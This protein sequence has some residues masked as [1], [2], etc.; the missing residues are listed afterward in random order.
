MFIIEK[1]RKFKKRQNLRKL[2]KKIEIGNSILLDGFELIGSC[3][4]KKRIRIGNDSM[5][6]CKIVFESDNGEVIIGD[7]VFLGDCTI[8]CR[9][10]IIFENDIFVA[11]GTYFYDHDS[12][13]SNFKLRQ[14][15]MKQQLNDFRR[16]H[17]FIKNKNWSVVKSG[18]IKV[19]SNSWIGMNCIILKR[20]TIGEG[21][22]IGAGSV[23]TKDILP[24]TVAAG[25][26]AKIVKNLKEKEV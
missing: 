15:D 3:N 4:N 19:S 11:W 24:W 2:R 22:I 16:G 13:S 6:A 21:A 1:I 14:E 23:V 5:L 7:R 26:P 18:E 8:I 12:H 9:S 25:N 10:K 17:D 20:V